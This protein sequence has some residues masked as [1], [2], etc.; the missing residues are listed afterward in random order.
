MKKHHHDVQTILVGEDCCMGNYYGNLSQCGDGNLNFLDDVLYMC[1][2]V[3]TMPGG[4]GYMNHWCDTG[5]QN[6]NAAAKDIGVGWIYDYGLMETASSHSFTLLSFIAAA[7][8]SK[9]E[10]WNIISYVD[11]NGSLVEKAS[12]EIK[13]SSSKAET[14]RFSRKGFSNIAAV[15]I[16]LVSLGSPG[17]TCTYGV[18]EQGYQFVFDKIRY[19]ESKKAGLRHDNGHLATPYM[20]KH[21]THVMPHIAATH[22][23]ETPDSNTGNAHP[24]DAAHTAGTAYHSQLLLLGHDSGLT[25]QFV[26]PQPEHFGT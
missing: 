1:Q 15:A 7:S 5:Y 2:S 8:W 23:V 4:S 20:L 19:Y 17:N 21:Q 10:P 25:G 9:N 13:V 11:D 6:V 12:D 14:I 16:S 3:W 24:H 26:L 22:A 18:G